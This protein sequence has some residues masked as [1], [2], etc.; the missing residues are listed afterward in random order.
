MPTGMLIAIEGLDGSG[1]QTQTALLVEKLKQL[2]PDRKVIPIS[3]PN[4]GNPSATMVETYLH[5]GLIQSEEYARS[6]GQY[7]Q[8]VWGIALMYAMDR[9]FTFTQLAPNETKS[10]RQLYEEGAIIVADR[11]TSSNVMYQAHKYSDPSLFIR[12][13]GTQEHERLG[14]PRP[15]ITF[16]LD[17][18]PSISTRNVDSRGETQDIY[19][20]LT[21][22][23]KTFDNFNVNI[24]P[25]VDWKIVNC[26]RDDKMR[27]IDEIHRDLVYHTT[28]S[29]G[30]SDALL[31]DFT[32][33][34]NGRHSATHEQ[35]E[36]Q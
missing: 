29:I 20:N 24:R 21:V 10:Y 31:K 35:E 19:E 2:Y 3:F 15:L 6:T 13:I 18:D 28:V 36:N 25:N 32:F 1:K 4:Y 16:Y 11:W 33:G 8:W 30:M 34:Y 9:F 7:D 17:V 5:G 26:F 12:L 14:L 27:T 22:Q 23:Q